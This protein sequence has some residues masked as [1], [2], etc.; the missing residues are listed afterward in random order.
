MLFIAIFRCSDKCLMNRVISHK[1][2]LTY[3]VRRTMKN[4]VADFQ[5][6]TICVTMYPG[7]LP[8]ALLFQPFPELGITV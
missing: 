5:P 3:L 1:I 2:V 7:A 8:Q 6:A 4:S